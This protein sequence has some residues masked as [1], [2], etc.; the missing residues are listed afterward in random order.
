MSRSWMDVRRIALRSLLVQMVGPMSYGI[1]QCQ[2]PGHKMP[3]L[4]CCKMEALGWPSG[5]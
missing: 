3:S 2:E 1:A 4:L 5:L